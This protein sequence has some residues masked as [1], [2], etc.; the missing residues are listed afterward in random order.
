MCA[1]QVDLTKNPFFDF[2]TVS[3]VKEA[4]TLS[5]NVAHCGEC[6]ACSTMHDMQ[7]M[8]DTQLTLTDDVVD[9]AKKAFLGGRKMGKS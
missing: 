4:H 3:N 8:T 7:I 1:V 2:K 9:C 6:G 5:R